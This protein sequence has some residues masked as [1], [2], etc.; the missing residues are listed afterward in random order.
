MTLRQVIATLAGTLFGYNEY[1][2]KR[3][4]GV[5]SLQGAWLRHADLMQANSQGANLEAVNLEAANLFETNLRGANL[6]ASNL[7]AAVMRRA[8]LMGADLRGADLR[9]AS[10]TDEQL[11]GAIVD[12]TTQLPY[13]NGISLESIELVRKERSGRARNLGPPALPPQP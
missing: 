7:Q 12:Q 11:A 6:R 3:K 9:G 5:E 4:L 2:L 13:R 10:L 1:R 8:N